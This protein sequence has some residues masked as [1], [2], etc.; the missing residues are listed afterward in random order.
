LSFFFFSSRRRHTRFSRDWSS[1]V[2][3]SDLV[4]LDLARQ[5]QPPPEIILSHLSSRP[6]GDRC[7]LELAPGHQRRFIKRRAAPEHQPHPGLE[8]AVAYDRIAIQEPHRMSMPHLAPGAIKV[9][10]DLGMQQLAD[11]AID[12]RLRSVVL[13]DIRMHCHSFGPGRP[14]AATMT[15]APLTTRPAPAA[16]PPE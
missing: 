4:P 13:P 5:T 2:C 6:I 1:D 16:C 10:V 3:S 15:C 12:R 8:P 7:V 14:T 9:L 11:L